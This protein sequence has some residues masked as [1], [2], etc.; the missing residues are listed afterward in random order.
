MGTSLILTIVLLSLSGVFPL[1]F[2]NHPY[3][4]VILKNN[5]F[6]NKSKLLSLRE[7]I[8]ESTRVLKVLSAISLLDGVQICGN[9][10]LRSVGAQ[11]YGAIIAFV[12]YYVIGLPIGIYLL[13]KTQ[14]K[15]L[16]KIENNF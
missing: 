1:I 9:G 6:K 13:I 16:G 14:L 12:G 7:I 10:I 11:T 3:V 2:T 5:I 4:I 8:V 15:V